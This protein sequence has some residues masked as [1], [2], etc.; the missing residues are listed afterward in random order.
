MP[1]KRERQQMRTSL[2]ALV[3]AA[4]LV[5]LISMG[6]A[7]AAP[8]G[9]AGAG[10]MDANVVNVHGYHCR[11]DWSRRYGWHRHW[12]ACNREYPSYHRRHRYWDEPRWRHERW[13]APRW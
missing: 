2:S 12:S 4:S 10:V 6:A 13:G 5:T 3:S 11:P 7:Q 8:A 1:R 9:L